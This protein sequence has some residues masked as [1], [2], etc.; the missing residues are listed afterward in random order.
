M[1][2]LQSY[3]DDILQRRKNDVLAAQWWLQIWENANV[4][5]VAVAEEFRFSSAVQ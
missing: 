4:E 2:M 1:C 3:V 5:N